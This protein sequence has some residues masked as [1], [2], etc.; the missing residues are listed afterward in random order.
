MRQQHHLLLRTLLM[1]LAIIATLTSC[2][3][4]DEPDTA[5]G[6][7]IEVEEGFL[8][9]GAE[10]HTDRYYSPIAMMKEVIQTAYP[11]NT[12][13][14]D[15]DAVILACD[16]LYQRYNEMYNGKAEHLTCLL[17]LVRA[18][19]SGEIVKKSERIRTYNFDINPIAPEE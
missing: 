3:K 2:S 18:N 15:D 9:N 16:K 19:L 7:Y 12:A 11:K 5:I 6:Y 17:H 13:S 1:M 10:D 8:V 14:G 4:D